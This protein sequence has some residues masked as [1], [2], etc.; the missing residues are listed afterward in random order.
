MTT[1]TTFLVTRLEGYVFPALGATDTLMQTMMAQGRGDSLFKQ[2]SKGF[3]VVPNP[4]SNE[5]KIILPE[6]ML[7]AEVRLYDATGRL[8]RTLTIREREHIFK[9]SDLPD[10]IYFL[11]T[12]VGDEAF[13]AKLVV[14]H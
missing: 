7:V 9:V 5:V 10:G 3:M 14:R 8:R 13:Q 4:A 2:S 12:G 1:S 11:K 6:G